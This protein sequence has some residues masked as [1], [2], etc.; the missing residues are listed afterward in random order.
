MHGP[1]SSHLNLIKRILRY[2][3]GTLDHDMH[4]FPSQ[5]SSPIA[6]SDAVGP[7]V[8]TLDAQTLVFAS[9]SGII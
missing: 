1:R 3:K 4:I 2:V 8:F 5:P 7:G 9:I 6:Y